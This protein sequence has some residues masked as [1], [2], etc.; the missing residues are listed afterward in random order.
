MSKME[1]YLLEKI[2]VNYKYPE[3][4]CI[5][6]ENEPFKGIYFILEGRVKIIKQNHQAK[7]V[8]W[9]AEQGEFIGVTSLYSHLGKYSFSAVVSDGYAKLLYLNEDLFNDLMQNQ[10]ELKEEI[11]KTL[12]LRIS[13]IEKRINSLKNQSIKKRLVDTLVFFT[14]QKEDKEGWVKIRCTLRDLAEILGSTR[15]YVQKVLVDFQRS[16]LVRVENNAMWVHQ[17]ILSKKQFK[18]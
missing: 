16:K 4:K 9:Y 8:M 2:Q 15:S 14:E 10:P 5:F 18:Y 12:C 1:K 13:Y 6:Q 11:I 3:G 17:K 7:M